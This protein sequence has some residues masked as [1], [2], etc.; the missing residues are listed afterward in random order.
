[1]GFFP[2]KIDFFKLFNQVTSNN[3]TAASLYVSLTESFDNIEARAKEIFELEQANDVFTHEIIK[4]LNSS[5]L[6]FL[7]SE[8]INALA[9]KLDDIMDLIWAATDRLNVFKLKEPTL[10]A[11]ELSKGLREIVDLVTK[12]VKKLQEKDYITVEECCIEINKLENKMDREYKFALATLFEEIKDP[13]LIIQ[14]KD[15]YDRIE[16]GADKCEDIA[17]ILENIVLKKT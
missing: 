4:K 2:K 13:V 7:D 11:I 14:W 1:M 5:Y 9:I 12:A 6:T 15:I 17:D 10:A 3:S 16:Y 8:D